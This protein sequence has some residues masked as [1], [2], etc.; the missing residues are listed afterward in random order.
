[1]TSEVRMALE[2]LSETV[3]LALVKK[4]LRKM[5]FECKNQKLTGVVLLRLPFWT[6]GLLGGVQGF[7]FLQ[8]FDLFTVAHGFQFIGKDLVAWRVQPS[9][10]RVLP[11]S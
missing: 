11:C 7:F 9:H 6:L 5:E 10:A 1:M 2:R 4:H 3:W 8:F